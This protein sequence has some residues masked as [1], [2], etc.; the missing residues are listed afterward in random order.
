MVRSTHHF[1]QMM[2]SMT[3]NKMTDK[4]ALKDLLRAIDTIYPTSWV[5]PVQSV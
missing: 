2:A 3:V 1:S 5:G 4:M